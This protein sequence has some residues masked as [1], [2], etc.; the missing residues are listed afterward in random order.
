MLQ[1]S[2][3]TKAY[4]GAPLFDG[5]SFVLRDGERAGLV[6]PNGVGKSTLL[7]LLAGVERPDRGA[8]SA[9]AGGRVGWL[10]QE[11]PDAA[12]TL[13]ELLGSGLGDV[14]RVRDELRALEA[15]LAR[16]DAS[17][18]TLAAFGRAQERFDALGGWALEATLDEARRAL[19]IDHLDPATPL[20]RLSGGEQARALLAGTLLAAPTVLLL[21]EPTNHLDLDGLRWLEGWLRGFAGTVLV[22]SHDRAFLDAV[23]GCVLELAPGGGR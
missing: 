21:D 1:A 4:D 23:V 14:W 3:L 16:G 20:S 5:L 17:D 19:A 22:V 6:G 12:R 8:A 7:A 15:R 11:A 2:D 9:G 13:G 18:Q 10:P